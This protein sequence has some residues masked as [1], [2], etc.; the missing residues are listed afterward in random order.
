VLRS[1][2]ADQ[3]LSRAIGLPR[4]GFPCLR[5]ATARWDRLASVQPA[6][7]DG[8]AQQRVVLINPACHN[9]VTTSIW[10]FGF[11]LSLPIFFHSRT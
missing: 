9:A 4:K 7:A 2:H 8:E 1:C 11:S 3:V 5:P 6:G 10:L